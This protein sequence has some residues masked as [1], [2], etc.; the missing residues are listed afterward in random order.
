MAQPPTRFCSNCGNVMEAGQRFCAQCGHTQ[1]T[2]GSQPTSLQASQSSGNAPSTGSGFDPTIASSSNATHVS[3]VSS[4]DSTTAAM[5]LTPPPPPG[6]PSM[7]PAEGGLTPPPPPMEIYPSA[8][9]PGYHAASTTID[10]P[11]HMPPQKPERPRRRGRGPALVTIIIALLIVG[12]SGVIFLPRLLNN[13]GANTQNEQQTQAALALTEETPG[14]TTITETAITP[15]VESTP[16]SVASKEV[17]FTQPLVFV[18][19]SVEFSILSVQ[20][21]ESFPDDSNYYENSGILRLNVREANNT[22]TYSSYYPTSDMLIVLPD[23]TTA[24]AAYAKESGSLDNGISRNN[25]ISFSVP[26]SVDSSQILLRLGSTE[27]VQIEVP[28]QE[29]ADTSKFLP[30]TASPDA[31]T[32]YGEMDWTITSVTASYS[33]EGE[34]VEAGKVYISLKIR[35]ENKGSNS[36]IASYYDYMRLQSGTNV[37]PLYEAD[38]PTSFDPGSSGE[39]NATFIVPEATDG[40]YTLKLLKGEGSY[41]PP[42]DATIDFQIN[43]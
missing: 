16:T 35:V 25:W 27:V 19:K 20:Q 13:S 40:K 2:T 12:A 42:E 6:G 17:T 33:Y 3:P 9:S 26:V 18:Y 24:K 11:E 5:S 36:Y 41:T 8:P 38:L 29:G 39:Y 10:P 34:Q 22:S 23:G 31:T 37:S 15:T 14:Q 21:A 7:L 32:K 1:D 30:K 4:D 28:L 43:E